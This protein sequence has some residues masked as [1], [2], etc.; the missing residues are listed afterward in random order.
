ML[1]F[2]SGLAAG[3]AHVVT[4]PDHLA[5]V[6]PLAAQEPRAGASLGLRWGLGH[7]LGAVALG[8]LGLLARG[9]F[10]LH[11]LSG[12]AEFMVGFVLIGVGLWALW[13][14]RRVV[15]HSHEHHHGDDAHHH[16]HVHD[17]DAA[18]VPASHRGHRHTVLAVGALHGA[19]GTGHLLAVVPSLA[20]PTGQA[21]VY[22]V[23]YFVAAVASMAAFGGLMGRLA[24]AGGPGMMR[25]LVQG[26]SVAAVVIG[27][28][29]IGNAWPA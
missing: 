6:A 12:G 14:S 3:A 15:V 27:V 21:V 8:L 16:V 25:W 17:G 20:L 5:A 18:H 7:G 29:W 11:A 2:L 28:F 10:D 24:G 19:A 1:I 9:V 13:R 22:L 4:G 23:A 26:A